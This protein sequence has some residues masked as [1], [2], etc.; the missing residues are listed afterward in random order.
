M[1]ICS[2]VTKEKLRHTHTSQLNSMSDSMV[3][4]LTLK[5]LACFLIRELNPI[6][7]AKA[8]AMAI[9][10]INGLFNY[11]IKVTPTFTVGR[12]RRQDI[13]LKNQI[14][15]VSSLW[16]RA[17]ESLIR[18]QQIAEMSTWLILAYC[19]RWF[20]SFHLFF[21]EESSLLHLEKQMKTA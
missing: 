17:D 18:Y 4:I 20:L 5:V 7:A 19:Y 11:S 1:F 15:S 10:L 13:L 3:Q 9:K 2:E 21:L 8:L 12:V 14:K 6:L 16:E